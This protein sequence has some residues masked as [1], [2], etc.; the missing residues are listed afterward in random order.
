MHGL[1]GLVLWLL[2][3]L[4][5]GALWSSPN[6]LRDLRGITVQYLRKLMGWSFG[7]ASVLS[8]LWGS[9]LISEILAGGHASCWC[10]RFASPRSFRQWP[11]FTG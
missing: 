4:G 11:P 9:W 8:L 7:I 6:I 5:L 2:V 1:N 10:V 3:A